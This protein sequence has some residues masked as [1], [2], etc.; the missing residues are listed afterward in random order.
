MGLVPFTAEAQ[1][2]ARPPNF[3]FI[4]ADDLGYNDFGCYGQKAFPTPHVDRLAREGMRFTDAH[5]PHALCSP[6]RYAVVTGTDP[7]R[8][9][10]TSHVIYNGE[11]LVIRPQEETIASLLRTGGYRTGIVGKWHLGLGDIMPRDLNHP[12]RGPNEVGFDYSYLVPDGHNMTPD[13]Y[14]ENGAVVGGTEPSYDSEVTVAL[15]SGYQMLFNNPAEGATWENRRPGNGIGASLDAKAVEFIEQNR[16]RPFFLY[17]PTCAVH[18]PTTPDPRLVGRSGIGAYGDFVMEFDWAVGRMMA[19]LDRLGLTENT[20][21]IVASDNG[22]YG[23]VRGSSHNTTA[24]WRGSKGSA[25]EGGHR[26][27]FIARWPHKIPAGSVSGQLISLVDLTATFCALAGVRLPENAA[28]DSFDL[29]PALLGRDDSLRVRETLVTGT[30]GMGQLVFRQGNWKL[31][32]DLKRNRRLYDLA[33]DPHEDR[34][35]AASRPDKAE[36][37]YRLL[38]TYLERGS[39]R[40]SAVGRP[41]SWDALL[42]ER[43]ER[44]RMLLEKFPRRARGNRPASAKD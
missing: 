17:Y 44:N 9:Y 35:I 32:M 8:R 1:V 18:F 43:D 40:R 15:R 29:T 39:S 22:G 5:S 20:L 38:M 28:L 26:V 23:A 3:I 30:K 10:H 16:D 7:Y 25:W 13:Y 19:T 42:N 4:M 31:I 24:P 12:G 36:E 27:P 37:L 11:P 21:L 34:D 41:T 33:A 6:T 14:L 2:P